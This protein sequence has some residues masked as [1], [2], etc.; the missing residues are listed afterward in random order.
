MRDI[1]LPILQFIGWIALGWFEIPRKEKV[2]EVLIPPTKKIK[3]V[4]FIIWALIPLLKLMGNLKNDILFWVLLLLF[5]ILVLG[6]CYVDAKEKVKAAKSI[7]IQW[8]PEVIQ[9]HEDKKENSI[10]FVVVGIGFFIVSC[11]FI[12]FTKVME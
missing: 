8:N 3:L 5:F 10:Y 2:G 1:L 9:A 7:G 11:A 6:F 12:L 4:R